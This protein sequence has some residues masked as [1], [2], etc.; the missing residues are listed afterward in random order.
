MLQV[1]RRTV[2]SYGIISLATIVMMLV[3]HSRA[4][5]DT[6]L[7]PATKLK[8]KPVVDLQAQPFE[9]SQIRLLD[10]PFKQAMLRDGQYLLSLD[11]D[12][13]LHTFR[14]N[15]GLPS[16]TEPLGG[17]EQPTCEVRGHFVGHYLS[18]CALL[19]AATGDEKYRQRANLLAQELA[20]CQQALGSSGYLSAYPESFIDRVESLQPV[21]AP[22]YTIHK[23]MAGLLDIHIYCDNAQALQ[24]VEGM[25]RWCQ[26]RCSKLAEEQMQRMLSRTEQGG[27]N[28]VLANLYAVTGK[29]EYLCSLVGLCNRPTTIR[30]PPGSSRWVYVC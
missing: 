5:A 24:V 25:A 14:L 2:K 16:T 1:Y 10:G 19:F 18:G 21:W 13:L 22:Y 4:E 15:A 28:E 8:A 29:P 20:R 3:N 11:P 6:S 30:S 12:R 9:L 17:W 7:L 26:S 23:I 27:M